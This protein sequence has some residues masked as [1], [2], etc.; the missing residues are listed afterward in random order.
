MRKFISGSKI[1]AISSCLPSKEIQLDEQ[2]CG[3]SSNEIEKI[4][5]ITGIHS[6]RY[7]SGET[8][9]DLCLLAAFELLRANNYS[10]C[11]IDAVIFVSQSRDFILPTTSSVI[12]SKLGLS[13]DTL[14]LD[15]PNGC[16]GYI[17]GLMLSS[18][19]VSAR[20]CR[21]VLLLCGETNSKLINPRDR[22]MAMI[23]G[24]AGTATL[25]SHS[26]DANFYFNIKTDGSGFDKIIIPSGGCR[27]RIDFS[28]LT[29]TERENGNFRSDFDMYMDGMSVFNFAITE[30]PKIL[31]ETFA[32]TNLGVEDFDLFAL[33]QANSLILKQIAKK[34]KLAE[35]KVP[36]S[37]GVIGNTGPASIPLLFTTNYS[38]DRAAS[39]RRVLAC[40]FG[41]GLNWG[42]SVFDLTGAIISSPITYC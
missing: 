35:T 9:S 17:Q 32:D 15:V 41:V 38:G 36:F 19:L 1:V 24:D 18:V 33:H 29:V 20:T 25:I 13:K 23:F 31:S 2:F 42:T 22:S 5:R 28:V 27:N 34:C 30:V 16:S 3:C 12:Q 37:A 11:D 21:N 39:L 40:G 10:A 7:S 26:D 4:T 8:S 6:V 14:A